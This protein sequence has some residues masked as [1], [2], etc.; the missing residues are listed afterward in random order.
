MLSKADGLISCGEVPFLGLIMAP[1]LGQPARLQ[2][3]GWSA[4]TVC[5]TSHPCFAY[6]LNV[7]AL[8]VVAA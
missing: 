7:L 6:C 2:S 1:E 8:M 3:P 4:A 5:S